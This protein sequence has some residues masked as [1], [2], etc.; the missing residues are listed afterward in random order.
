MTM[1]VN[2][3]PATTVSVM[4]RG[5]QF[6]DGVFETIA[7]VNGRPRFLLLHLERLEFGCERLGIKP[8]N[9]DEI[10]AEVLGLVSGV[11]RAI[12]KVLVTAG[13][14]VARGYARSG[15]ETAT[16]IT[17]RYPWPHDDPAQLHDGVMARTLTSRLGE[18]PRLA[19]LKHCNRLE[20]ILARRE[21]DNDPHLAEGILYSS[22]GN[23]VS[24]TMSNVFLVRESCL[25]TPRIDLCGVAG[26]MRRVVLREARRGGIPARECELR[27]ENLQ[28]A[29]EIFLTNA[30]IGIWPLRS[31]DD[32][33]LT[34]GPVTRHL[35]SVL[36]PLLNEPPDA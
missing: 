19:G 4:D 28:A 11:E 16:R 22:C 1:L 6:G 5:V 20:Q 14:A 8:P 18:N 36:Q 9:L 27:A 13:E 33:V 34:P 35:Q 17:I 12:V 10:T 25:L 26:V 30:R 23:L 15:H 24:G 3:V 7:C 21:L 29:D 2:G 32:R 31:L